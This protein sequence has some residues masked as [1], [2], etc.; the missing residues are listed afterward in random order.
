MEMMRNQD[1]LYS[2]QFEI[3]INDFMRVV[4]R[5]TSLVE[6]SPILQQLRTS[7]LLAYIMN[8]PLSDDAKTCVQNLID[9]RRSIDPEFFYKFMAVINMKVRLA[10]TNVGLMYQSYNAKVLVPNIEPTKQLIN[11]T[12]D[13]RQEMLREDAKKATIVSKK[14]IQPPQILRL[15]I[16]DDLLPKC[17]NAIADLNRVIVEGNRANGFTTTGFINTH[18]ESPPNC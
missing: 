4:K 6:L 2:P 1:L 17:I 15:Q 16:T 10:P 5:E 18:I 8:D 14:S 3:Y 12:M 11:L 7:D 9:K 13:A